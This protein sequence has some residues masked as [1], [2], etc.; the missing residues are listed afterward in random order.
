MMTDKKRYG[1]GSLEE[2]IRKVRKMVA[3][4]HDFS[5]KEEWT[6]TATPEEIGEAV[7]GKGIT[8]RLKKDAKNMLGGKGSVSMHDGGGK[9][10]FKVVREDG[11]VQKDITIQ[12]LARIVA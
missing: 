3:E 7:A 6:D 8:V 2:E 11:R 9:L 12:Q 10:R 1:M 5:A 4:G